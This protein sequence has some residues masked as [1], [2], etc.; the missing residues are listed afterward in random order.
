MSR[1]RC[2]LTLTSE[3]TFT[4]GTQVFTPK[5][6]KKANH[7]VIAA[8]ITIATA[9]YE[10]A[11]LGLGYSVRVHKHNVCQRANSNVLAFYAIY[12]SLNN[13]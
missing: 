10:T 9:N 3:Y 8:A 7:I 11:H 13:I 5:K 6:E 4:Q 1:L 12:D 2:N